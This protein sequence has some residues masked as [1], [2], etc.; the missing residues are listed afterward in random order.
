[1]TYGISLL[2]T[3][4]F[5]KKDIDYH[6]IKIEKCSQKQYF[7]FDIDNHAFSNLLFGIVHSCES[8]QKF[9]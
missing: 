7:Y 5:T 2:E 3:L 9:L 1:M 4:Y 6:Y 8:W